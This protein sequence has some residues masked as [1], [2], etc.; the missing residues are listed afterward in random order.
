MIVCQIKAF[1]PIYESNGTQMYQQALL[2]GPN[3]IETAEQVNTVRCQTDDVFYCDDNEDY[4]TEQNEGCACT[5]KTSKKLLF[6]HHA[7][8]ADAQFQII[9]NGISNAKQ[10]IN[11]DVDTWESTV[12]ILCVRQVHV[13]YVMHQFFLLFHH[14]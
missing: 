13:F 12:C 1:L 5:N 10:D 6:V 11:I 4:L 9:Q 14:N 2:S 3:F 8:A 7:G